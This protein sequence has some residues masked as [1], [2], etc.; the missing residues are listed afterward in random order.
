MG[1]RELFW[2]TI[3]LDAEGHWRPRITGQAAIDLVGNGVGTHTGA[4]AVWAHHV[5]GRIHRAIG[6][7]DAA[8]AGEGVAGG[9]GASK[10]GDNTFLDQLVQR[11]IP[12]HAV[13]A[14]D[15]TTFWSL[16][17]AQQPPLTPLLA[18]RF[19]IAHGGHL[20]VKFRLAQNCSE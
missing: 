3:G 11:F 20:D 2:A 18:I 6:H 12:A 7:F 14:I 15:V 9:L 5:T 10:E 19:S 16:T 4:F 1:G 8:V 13:A 17:D